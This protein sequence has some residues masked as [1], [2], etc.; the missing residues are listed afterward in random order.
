MTQRKSLVYARDLTP[1][2]P[3]GASN[4]H[5]L[6]IGLIAAYLHDKLGDRIDVELFKYPQDLSD[7]LERQ[8]PRLLGFSNYSW[9]CNLSYEYVKRVKARHP[10]TVFVFGGPNYGLAPEE[11]HA[12]WKRYPLID[13]YVLKEG[14]V[15]LVKLIRALEAF[16][17]D[18]VAL[19]REGIVVPST[20]YAHEGN[21]CAGRCCRALTTSTT[22]RRRTARA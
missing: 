3:T 22:F 16:E 7:A 14:E 15:A 12:F 2:R 11:Q 4:T 9:N 20:H 8:T 13:F 18:A 19:K 21:L 6:A 10:G 5:P 1:Y 17:F